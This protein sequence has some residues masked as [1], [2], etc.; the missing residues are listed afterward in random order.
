MRY[1]NNVFNVSFKFFK[2]FKI[3]SFLFFILYVFTGVWQRKAPP[4]IL[5]AQPWHQRYFA[6]TNHQSCLSVCLHPL[7]N[8]QNNI[9]YAILI[10]YPLLLPLLSVI[11]RKLEVQCPPTET[12][13]KTPRFS[14]KP[15]LFFLFVKSSQTNSQHC[16]AAKPNFLSQFLHKKCQICYKSAK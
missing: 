11:Y 7:P 10:G 12:Q 5:F 15:V 6:P 13:I 4:V 14:C 3:Y 1:A 16:Q 9:T 8:L 2:A